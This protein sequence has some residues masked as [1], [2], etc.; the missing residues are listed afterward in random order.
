MLTVDAAKK[1]LEA[2]RDLRGLILDHRDSVDVERKLPLPVIQALAQ[3]GIFRSM[4][5]ES[6]GGEEWDLL[7]WLR[8][9][10]ELSIIE[11]AV[12]W[13]AGVG[14]SVNAFTTGWLSDEVARAVSEGPIGLVAGVG[15]PSGKA[16][17]VDGGYMVNGRW[18]FASSGAHASWFLAR[19][20]M[21]D[22]SGPTLCPMMYLPAR[23][24]EI[25][26]TW[27]V[28]GMRGTDSNDF[29]VNELFVP[30]ERTFD[31]L[32][33]SPLHSGQLYRMP[34]FFILASG[35][36]PL[37]LGMARGAIDYFI[38]LM[39][40]RMDGSTGTLM[41][42]RPTIQ[43]RLAKAEAAVRSAR[44]LFFETMEDNWEAV[45]TQEELTERQSALGQLALTNA[46]A[47]GA[48]AIDL[49]YHAAGTSSIF[50]DNRLERYFRDV[51]V[52][53][54]HRSATPEE[55]FKVGGV[56]LGATQ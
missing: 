1:K 34:I 6:A 9:V 22:D 17:R 50:S 12:G 20:S 39:E 21:E 45:G 27:S 44:A 25:I 41:R 10:E 31:V 38:E 28:G 49:I 13:T 54:Q 24:V 32:A 18:R 8:V 55:L 29:S 48:R 3:L 30:T 19:Y 5:P 11:G 4:V 23:E 46:V 51:H 15:M 43:E 47:S 37:C 42:D 16:R 53:T 7:T 56:L 33:D 26:D 2:A 14:G 40:T 35:L 36:A 52:A